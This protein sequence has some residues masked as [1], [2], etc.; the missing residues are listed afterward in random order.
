MS[1]AIIQHK[2]TDLEILGGP[3]GKRTKKFWE[4]FFEMTEEEKK[5]YFE[6]IVSEWE[7]NQTPNIPTA[8]AP[9]CTSKKVNRQKTKEEIRLLECFLEQD[10]K[11]TKKTVKSASSIL[12]LSTYQVYKWGY[13]RK[14]KKVVE[15][16]TLKY[17]D[18]EIDGSTMS[19]ITKEDQSAMSIEGMDFNKQVDNI[20]LTNTKYKNLQ[21][22]TTEFPAGDLNFLIDDDFSEK[23]FSAQNWKVESNESKVHLKV[24]SIVRYPKK[25]NK[26]KKA[27]R[28][29]N[30]INNFKATEDKISIPNEMSD[31]LRDKIFESLDDIWVSR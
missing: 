19:R 14:N 8:T 3:N 7:Y 21:D 5:N 29:E 11:W 26:S 9:D 17:L 28:F 12:G 4:K 6:K 20:V 25:V 23:I 22:V 30:Y 27:K 13:D 10:P 16:E 2:A 24:F 1:S 18:S 31:R 15:Y